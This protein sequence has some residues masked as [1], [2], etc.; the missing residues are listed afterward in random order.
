MLGLGPTKE[1]KGKRERKKEE[2]CWVSVELEPTKE[3]KGKRERRKEEKCWVSVGLE[4]TKK[5]KGKRERRK[6]IERIQHVILHVL[7][8]FCELQG[9]L[10]LWPQFTFPLRV[11]LCVL[12]ST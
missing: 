1:K 2:K 9:S 11:F 10:H 4:P 7:H 3:K 5:K 6:C 12:C 8:L